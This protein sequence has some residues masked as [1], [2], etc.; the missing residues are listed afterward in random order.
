MSRTRLRNPSRDLPSAQDAYELARRRLPRLIF[1]F[2]D[3]AAGQGLASGRNRSAFGDIGLMPRVLVDPGEPSL[4]TEFLG[5]TYGTPFGIAPMG[6]CDL[7]WPG[8]DHAFARLA[9]QKGFPVCVSTA[10]STP[11]ER[12][13]ELAEGQAWFQL[14]VTGSTE[15]ALHFVERAHAAGYRELVLT[16][17]VPRL[18]RRPRDLRNGFRTPFRFTASGILDFA[19]HPRWSLGT[20]MAGIPRMANYDALPQSGGYDRQAARKGADWAFLQQLRDLWKGRLIV[21]GVLSSDDALRI[22]TLGCDALWISNH[23]GRQLESAPATAAILPE[24]RRVLPR[25]FPLIVDGGVTCGEDIVKAL[26][27]GADFVMLG[28]PFLY[29]SAAVGPE[30]PQRFAKTLA[31]EIIVTLA[32]IGGDRVAGIDSSVLTRLPARDFPDQDAM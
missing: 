10:S 3:G 32:Q 19:T 23:G 26:A 29:A 9:A 20:L 4:Q 7:A 17:D 31:D 16:V 15:T 12:M 5:R 28:R 30:G 2:I 18:G 25:E 21:K 27:L 24:M 6:M 22:R 11:L 1:D 8:T 14:Y 13:V